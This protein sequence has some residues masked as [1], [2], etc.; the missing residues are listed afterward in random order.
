MKKKNILVTGGT[1]FIGSNISRYLVKQGHKVTLFDNNFRGK[2]S[3]IKD[4]RK[5]IMDD[6]QLTEIN[7]A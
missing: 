7:I 6:L 2:S 3:R 4:I 5:Q 1:G